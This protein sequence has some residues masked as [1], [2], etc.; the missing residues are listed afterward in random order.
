VYSCLLPHTGVLYAADGVQWAALQGGMQRVPRGLAV[1]HI[2]SR[3]AYGRLLSLQAASTSIVIAAASK[4]LGL[5]VLFKLR[6][7]V[8]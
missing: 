7:L 6:G 5:S 3:C 4:W 2:P 1:G 8:A